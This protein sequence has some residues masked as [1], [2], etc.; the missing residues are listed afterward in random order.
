MD[1]NSGKIYGKDRSLE[2]EE[3]NNEVYDEDYPYGGLPKKLNRKGDEFSFLIIIGNIPNYIKTTEVMYEGISN[4]SEKIK[5]FRM[6]VFKQGCE[7]PLNCYHFKLNPE[8]KNCFSGYCLH[9][10]MHFTA[11]SQA[12]EINSNPSHPLNGKITADDINFLS[13]EI[14]FNVIRKYWRFSQKQPLLS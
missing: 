10:G 8:G 7:Y 12:E 13:W 11:E 4:I 9:F 3:G 2:S 6:V 14:P 5:E 1:V